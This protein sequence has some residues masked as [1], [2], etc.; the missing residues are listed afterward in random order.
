MANFS[1]H[2]PQERNC[3]CI[4]P[5]LR[6]IEEC[7]FFFLPAVKRFSSEHLKTSQTKYKYMYKLIYV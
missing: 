7:K 5:S 6:Q 3:K 2:R 4:F 1:W